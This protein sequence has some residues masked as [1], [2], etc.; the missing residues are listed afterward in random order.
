MYPTRKLF[1]FQGKLNS[2]MLQN[3]NVQYK[4]NLHQLNLKPLITGWTCT[5]KRLLTICLTRT[6]CICQHGWLR[7]G[8]M[9]N[10]WRIGKSCQEVSFFWAPIASNWSLC[11]SFL[12]FQTHLYPQLP[13]IEP[14]KQYF[15]QLFL[16][17]NNLWTKY[18]ML[19]PVSIFNF[20]P[21][22]ILN[23]FY[24]FVAL[25]INQNK[26]VCSLSTFMRVWRDKYPNVIIPKNHR[27]TECKT[28]SHLKAVLK[29]KLEVF[30]SDVSDRTKLNILQEIVLS[31]SAN[32][33]ILRISET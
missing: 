3:Q 11:L 32:I 26:S 9:R 2:G 19:W 25:G 27:F 30:D 8:F 12:L 23:I 6:R 10:S 13:A 15:F 28:C 33:T 29:G 22:C 31:R 24:Y 21:L 17:E 20:Y 5:L 16:N 18:H 4:R 7:H 14:E 1:N